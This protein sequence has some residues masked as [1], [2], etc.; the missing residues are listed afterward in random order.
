MVAAGLGRLERNHMILPRRLRVVP[1][2]LAV[3]LTAAP[4]AA[5]TNWP[6][7]ARQSRL[8]VTGP[9]FEAWNLITRIWSAPSGSTDPLR[10]SGSS[11]DPFGNPKPD[12]Q[13]P[14]TGTSTTTQ[15]PSG[16]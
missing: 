1:L 15:L 13:S 3:L 4:L 8:S 14:A 12:S 2:L 7:E 9:L 5:S 10:K 6:R 16:N 11:I